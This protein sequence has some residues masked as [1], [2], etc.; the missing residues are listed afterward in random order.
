M[1]RICGLLLSSVVAL[2]LVACG[3]ETSDTLVYEVDHFKVACTGEASQLCM[4]VREE[5]E[6][7]FEFFY[8]GI[9]DFDFQWGR[10]YELEVEVEE[11]EDPMQDAS[12]QRHKL[13][14]VIS[15]ETVDAGTSFDFR[16]PT[17]APGNTLFLE[18][19]DADATGAFLDGREFECEPEAACDE[20]RQFLEDEAGFVATFEYG[21]DVDGALLMTAATAE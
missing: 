13:L 4:Q 16:V 17:V 12:S 2:S 8:S 6:E 3:G 21:E 20:A 1:K 11:V 14:E 5:G 10:V 18:V 19:D 7:D 9:E 15:E